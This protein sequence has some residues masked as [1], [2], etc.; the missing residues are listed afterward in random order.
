MVTMIIIKYDKLRQIIKNLQNSISPTELWLPSVI[1][2]IPQVEIDEILVRDS[3][4]F[5]LI[6]E[7]V[8][9]IRVNPDCYLFLKLFSIWVLDGI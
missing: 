4:L 3:R 9:G 6:L 5:S 8:D 7:V 2:T 1:N